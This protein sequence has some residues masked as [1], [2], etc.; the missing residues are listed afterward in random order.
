MQA[1]RFVH[2]ADLH[3]DAAFSGITREIP[4]D[5]GKKLHESTFVALARLI[6]LCER[7]R[8][9]FLILAGDVHNHEDRSLRAQLALRDGCERLARAGVRVFI[10]HGNH[11]PLSSRLRNIHW[12]ENV[13]FFAEEVS[14]V[15]VFRR[16]AGEGEPPA[17]LVHGVSHAGPRESRNLALRFKRGEEACFQLGVLHCSL[18]GIGNSRDKGRYA[19][20]SLEDLRESGLDY[21]ALGHIHDGREASLTPPVVY[22]GCTQGL[23]INEQGE[24]GCILA[25]VEADGAGGYTV[26][27][28]F[29]PLGPVVWQA[30][31]VA[32]DDPGD[33]G[34]P[35]EQDAPE[36]SLDELENRL[37]QALDAAQ[38]AQG[39]G[40]EVLVVRLRLTGRTSLDALLRRDETRADILSRLRD[41]EPG[42]RG[43][44]GEGRPR[45]WIKDL[46]I[47][48]RPL[49]QRAIL[50][51]RE[52]LLGE[53]IRLGEACRTSPERLAALRTEAL[54]PLFGHSRIGRMLEPLP[55]ED[56][57]ALLDDAESLCMDLLEDN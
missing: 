3:L 21:W 14:S 23:H 48:T 47:L 28:A 5:L 44:D 41:W 15:P 10:A 32:L 33:P 8:P 56:V 36:L 42:G 46:E 54:A 57:L 6:E 12:P 29:R 16:G 38:E 11:D 55:D 18:A 31:S 49:L 24:K 50:A 17:A 45:L 7:E 2:A 9:D 20:C 40:C 39:P 35:G 43:Q 30:V 51:E 52:D 1:I 13:T 27:R 25:T 53:I 22:P 37:R 26:T 34:K 4:G 19:P